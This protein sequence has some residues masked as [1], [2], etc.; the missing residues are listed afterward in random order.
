[1]L[2]FKFENSEVSGGRRLLRYDNS[3]D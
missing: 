3:R 2:M 1:M